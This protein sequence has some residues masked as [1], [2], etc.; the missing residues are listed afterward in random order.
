VATTHLTF[1]TRNS[2]GVVIE[3]EDTTDTVVG[4]SGFFAVDTSTPALPGAGL[5]ITYAQNNTGVL[6]LLA[7]LLGRA[8]DDVDP[9]TT[10]TDD[11]GPRKFDSAKGDKGDKDGGFGEDE[12]DKDKKKSDDGKD[13]K[14]DEKPSKKQVAQCS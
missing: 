8:V 11:N 7:N 9:T 12:D 1:L 5:E 13:G 6:A 3:G 14:K 2:G 10:P 4:G